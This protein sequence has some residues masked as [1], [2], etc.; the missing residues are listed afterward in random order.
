MLLWTWI[1][2]SFLCTVYTVFCKDV[3][4]WWIFFPKERAPS[5]QTSQSYSILKKC[6]IRLKIR[7]RDFQCKRFQIFFVYR[8]RVR[9][10]RER[11][12]LRGTVTAMKTTATA[13]TVIIMP[14]ATCSCC[15]TSLASFPSSQNSSRWN[16]GGSGAE[17]HAIYSS[18]LMWCKLVLGLAIG[19]QY[20]WGM[21][22]LRSL[23][24]QASPNFCF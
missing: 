21:S 4:G 7:K 10:N 12:E 13:P 5:Q 14:S 11:E 23:F 20:L 1:S 22:G 24:G 17:A 18:I 3:F 9:T 15:P 2:L 19:S 16:S 6:L 8:L